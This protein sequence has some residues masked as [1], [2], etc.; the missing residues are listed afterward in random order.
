MTLCDRFVVLITVVCSTLVRCTRLNTAM[1]RL[2][3]RNRVGIAL[4]H[5][6]DRCV[7]E[8]HLRALKKN[9][10]LI[11][12][13]LLVDALQSGDWGAIPPDAMVITFD[14]GMKGS[15]ELK[16]ILAKNNVPALV[17]LVSGTVGSHR[18]FW[19]NEIEDSRCVEKLKQLP[20]SVR[21]VYLREHVDYTDH[22]EYSDRQA[23]STE[24]IHR[25]M[26]AG[27]RFGCH[28]ASHPILPRCEDS[29]AQ[30]EIATA[31]TDLAAKLGISVDHFSY[32]NGD[33]TIRDETLVR[34]AGYRSAR[35]TERGLN[36]R[37]TNPYR[38]KIVDVLEDRSV[39]DIE[40]IECR[41]IWYGLKHFFRKIWGHIS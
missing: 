3:W 41:L 10:N 5:N 39:A 25:M 32:P 4:Y 2:I 29:V 37:D 11:S 30:E 12:L 15:Y 18:H 23:L 24:E 34:G 28:T 6:V 1:R 9:Y 19:F 20:N 8:S 40:L 36:G 21:L 14:D 17:Y 13:D 16:E 35:T 27:V 22:R 26:E 33:Y 38:M 7:F 31:K